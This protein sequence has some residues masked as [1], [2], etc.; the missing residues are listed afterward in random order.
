MQL[1]RR[2]SEEVLQIQ[3][4]EQALADIRRESRGP[5]GRRADQVNGA[6]S[7]VEN[8]AAIIATLEVLLDLGAH[9]VAQGSIEELGKRLKQ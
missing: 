2:L 8:G 7:C 3:S 9:L 6:A 4:L 1:R 5:F